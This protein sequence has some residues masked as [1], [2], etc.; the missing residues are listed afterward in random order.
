MM[1]FCRIAVFFSLNRFVSFGN[2]LESLRGCASRLK[3]ETM[4]SPKRSKERSVVHTAQSHSCLTMLK[5][6]D[7][8]EKIEVGEFYEIDRS[9]LPPRTPSVLLMSVR[10]VKVTWKTELNVTVV[11]PSSKSLV[12]FFDH[13]GVGGVPNMDGKFIMGPELADE[14]LVRRIPSQEFM[15][16]SKCESFW[17][18][19]VIKNDLTYS[20]PVS[21]CNSTEEEDIISKKGTCLIRL[22]GSGLISWGTRRVVTYGDPQCSVSSLSE[23]GGGGDRKKEEG[24]EMISTVAA[25]SRAPRRKMGNPIH[26]CNQTSRKLKTKDKKQPVEKGRWTAVRYDRATGELLKVLKNK[27]AF[28]GN[29]ISRCQ[30]RQEAR[31]HI[32][33]TG[34]LDHL[35]KHV[36]GKVA[37]DGVHRFRRRFDPEGVME[38]WLESADLVD[39]RKQAGVQDPFWTPAPGWHAG[40]PVCTHGSECTAEIK[41][42]RDELAKLKGEMQAIESVNEGDLLALDLFPDC[43]DSV[44][45][46]LIP[47]FDFLKPTE[48]KEKYEEML[49]KKAEVEQQLFSISETL[50]DMEA[51]MTQSI[52][53]LG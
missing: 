18:V 50:R 22:Q 38:Y 52:M 42:L 40:D 20:I 27:R 49:K 11:Y 19:Q 15:L 33:D 48:L 14:V 28:C 8:S 43:F 44:E 45:P 53:N 26:N 23:D 16:N 32:G 4:V 51:L 5:F 25:R 21:V 24:I 17:S 12:T 6:G 39:L 36:A 35:L 29:P 30:L 41:L 7:L 37:P 34:L 46:F 1:G 31:K 13:E 2:L 47:D 10:V 9:K 3:A